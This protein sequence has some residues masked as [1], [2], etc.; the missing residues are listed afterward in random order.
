MSI[1]LLAI[2]SFVIYNSVIFSLLIT[3][4]LVYLIKA[5]KNR[6]YITP[7]YPAITLLLNIGVNIGIAQWLGIT[8]SIPLFYTGKALFGNII[9]VLLISLKLSGGKTRQSLVPFA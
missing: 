5:V 4:P 6:F 3:V 1:F 7:L 8:S 9:V 2:E